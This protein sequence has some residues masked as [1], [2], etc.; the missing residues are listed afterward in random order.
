MTPPDAERVKDL[1]VEVVARPETEWDDYLRDACA[2]DDDLQVRVRALA[3]AWGR[4]TTV[5]RAPEE[6]L[7][8][9]HEETFE[10]I[11]DK[12]GA[13]TLTERLGEGGFGVVYRAV[14][15][16]PIRRELAI[17]LLKPG[18]DSVAVLARFDA[19]RQALARLTHPSIARI[20]DAGTTPR[21]RPFFA[22]ELV[23]GEPI[24]GHCDAR[25]MAIEARLRLFVRVCDAV[26]HAHQKGIIHRDLKPSNVLVTGEGAEA[27]PHVI[28][29]GI[30]KA[31]DDPLTDVSVLTLA[32]QVI[33]TPRY[34]S[35]EQA[36]LDAGA[37]DTRSDV[38]SLGAV[39]YELVCG[40]TPVTAEM[41][42]SS[43]IGRMG[44]VFES[45]AFDRPSAR[46]ARDPKAGTIGERR[47]TDAA[48]LQR[49][50]GGDL[51]WI[52]MRAIEIEPGRR[53]PS[54]WALA[55]DIERSLARQPVEARPPSRVYLARRFA[56]RHRVGVAIAGAGLA[57]VVAFVALLG[58]GF[59]KVR[60]ERNLAVQAQLDAE[61]A[62]ENSDATL[63]YFLEVFGSAS[64]EQL[65]HEVT[66]LD[67]VSTSAGRIDER[68]TGR[69]ALGARIHDATGNLFRVLGR[70]EE[71]GGHL[72]RAVELIDEAGEGE[73]AAGVAVL[74]DYALYVDDAG[75]FERFKE[76][77]QEA[78]ARARRALPE[79][80]P[81]RLLVEANIA[82]MVW[83]REGRH[84]EA[85]ETLER[86]L[87]SGVTL[88]TDNTL[89]ATNNLGSALTRVGRDE[90]ARAM[91]ERVLELASADGAGMWAGHRM[92][93][94]NNLAGVHMRRGEV[95]EGL[96]KFETVLGVLEAR[97]GPASP[98]VLVA[99]NNIAAAQER[100]GQL[101]EALATRDDL[102]ARADAMLPAGHPIFARML[103]GRA[104]LL[105]A[106]DRADEAEAALLEARAILEA[107][108]APPQF[109]A[110]N[111]TDLEA[112]YREL[113][114]D[115]EADRW[116]AVAAPILEA[117]GPPTP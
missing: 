32:S 81:E 44:E 86:V 22:M 55:R 51:D 5:V 31:M 79:H 82:G 16:E 39:L 7:H 45:R 97:F 108:S 77:M 48:K 102:R 12:V 103:G 75:D 84:E 15:D 83:V 95:A 99:L 93:A 80:D 38:F 26:H 101:D 94:L 25:A 40:S 41:V 46:L 70:N 91:F 59:A 105:R 85:I 89:T 21:G 62:R 88:P 113:G 43:G 30:A 78:L 73:S 33:G 67:A 66:V 34:M 29:F 90:D 28:D 52:V 58:V 36:S 72:A 63:A 64:G 107:S 20:Y 87:G 111:A 50:L 1:L 35:P 8:T 54:A 47:G 2:G 112:F 92:A 76:L 71:A 17:K 60:H 57:A 3:E 53:Y 116:A 109:V 61:L 69:P 100:L 11:G 18:M 115:E 117:L 110:E 24:T 4:A 74:N 56:R 19:E 106:M 10:K 104:G 68:F 9:G 14:Q 65:G 114:R 27:T 98:N 42:G 6:A 49:E 37:V 23:E 96:A 13:Y